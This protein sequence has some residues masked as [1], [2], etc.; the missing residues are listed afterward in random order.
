MESW[1]RPA[2]ILFAATPEGN[3]IALDASDGQIFVAVPNRLEHGRVT[4][5][6]CRRRQTVHRGR[7]RRRRLWFRPP[8]VSCMTLRTRTSCLT[9]LLLVVLVTPSMAQ[10][11]ARRNGELHPSSKTRKTRPLCRSF[12]SVGNI[13]FEM[14][15]KGQNVLRWP[16]PSLEEF[17]ARPA[18][19][20]IPFLGP[21]ANRS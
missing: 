6:L 2:G 3:L 13:T 19:S 17:K 12:R 14:K 1:Q 21:W 8:G 5:E 7:S 10:Y 4:N 9:P 16:F 18:L 20:G 15:V 11:S